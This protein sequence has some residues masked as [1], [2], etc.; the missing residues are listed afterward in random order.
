MTLIQAQDR[1]IG[2][3]N[4]CHPGHFRRVKRSAWSQLYQWAVKR[5]YAK[6]DAV[7][8]CDEADQVATLQRNS[9]D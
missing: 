3:I 4:A 2:R 9:E 6:Q 8:I 7:V 1:Y 5:G